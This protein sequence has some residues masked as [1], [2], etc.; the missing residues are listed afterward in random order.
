MSEVIELELTGMAYGGDAFGRDAQGRMVFVSFSIPGEQVRVEIVEEHTRWA[1]ARLLDVMQPSPDRVRPRC[2]HF[3]DCGGC[4]YQHMTYEAQRLTKEDILKDQLKRIGGFEQPPVHPTVPSR[5]PWNTRNHLQFKLTPEG[6][7]GFNTAASDRILP[8]DECH[9]P[10][11]ALADL[12]PRIELEG[13][14]GIS[15]VA[16]R[17]GAEEDLMVILKGES[18]PAVEMQVD[19]PVSVVWISEGRRS[20]LAGDPILEMQ[21]LDRSFVV[22]P[23]SFFQVNE[24]L[25]GELVTRTLDALD[26]RPGTT[27]FDLYAGVGLFSVFLAEKGARVVAVEESA[28]ACADFELNLQDFEDI[29]LYEAP[30][31]MA[32]PQ[33]P[34]RPEAIIVDPPR[35]G[36][37]RKALDGILDRG[38]SQLVYVSCDA[39]TFARDAKRLNAAGYRLM[40]ATPIDLFPQ[41]YHIEIFSHWRE[42]TPKAGV[43]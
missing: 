19:A 6:R 29:Q 38:A 27:I 36:L 23:G 41:T 16:V 1:R 22:S 33:I 31:E 21:V 3:A 35:A 13:A 15:R 40:H 26:V 4:H 5:S 9:L 20:T 37:S 39:A 10:K 25:A 42:A 18:K 43:N 17:A 30:V 32:L 12:W 34:E 11:P 28:S 24:A 14:S 2:K 8:I 7:L